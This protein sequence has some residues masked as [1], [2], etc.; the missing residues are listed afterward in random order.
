[1]LFIAEFERAGRSPFTVSYSHQHAQ[2]MTSQI[3]LILIEFEA[4]WALFDLK[5]LIFKPL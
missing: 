3:L 1:M 5:L 4:F 2:H